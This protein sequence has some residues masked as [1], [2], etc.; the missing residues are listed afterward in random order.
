MIYNLNNNLIKYNTI[1]DNKNFTTASLMK[2]TKAQLI[3]TIQ[4]LNGDIKGLNDRI[5]SLDKMYAKDAEDKEKHFNEIIETK[6]EEIIELQNNYEHECDEHMSDYV[7][8]RNKKRTAYGIAF[9]IVLIM[10][11]YMFLCM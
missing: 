8:F 4:D 7:E 6:N 1:M 5:D 9:A 10:S 11:I 3:A 2:L